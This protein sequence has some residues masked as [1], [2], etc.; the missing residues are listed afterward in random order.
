MSKDIDDDSNLTPG[1]FLHGTP[2]SGVPDID[3]VDK[4]KLSKY[5]QKLREILKSRF[6]SE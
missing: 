3:I 5:V 6:R 1:K 4:S 2:L